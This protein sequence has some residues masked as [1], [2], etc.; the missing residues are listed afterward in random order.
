METWGHF[1]IFLNAFSHFNSLGRQQF[2]LYIWTLKIYFRK[3][4]MT[5]AKCM[6]LLT[7]LLFKSYAGHID[8]HSQ[9]PAWQTCKYVRSKPVCLTSVLPDGTWGLEVE[10][11]WVWGQC[12]VQSDALSQDKIKTCHTN[13]SQDYR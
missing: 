2:K 10:T 11:I 12:G 6:K 4:F 13:S 9:I 7:N 1:N 3:K 8:W 5:A